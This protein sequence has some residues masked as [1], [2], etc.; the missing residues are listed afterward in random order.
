MN[1]LAAE[2]NK[3]LEGTVAYRLLSD[4]GRRI[5]FPKGIIAQSSEA[6]EK[7]FF[8]NATIG[9]ACKDGVPLRLSEVGRNFPL[10][11][12]AESVGYAPT[13]GVEEL[14]LLWKEQIIKKNPQIKGASISMPVIAPGITAGISYTAD[15]FM[16]AGAQVMAGHPWWDNYSL[17]FEER[18]GAVLKKLSF[19]NSSSSSLDLK[20]IEKELRKEAQNGFLRVILNFPNN[21]SGYS[22][23]VSEAARLVEIIGSI[24]EAGTDVLVLCDDAYFGLFYEEETSKESIFGSLCA[25]NERVLAV[26]IDGPTKEDYVW[27]LRLAAVT[28]GCKG[29]KEDAYEALIKKMMGA[30]RSSVSC[31]SSAS[32]FAYLKACKNGSKEEK[33]RY[34]KMLKERYLAV[35]EF[36]A[37]RESPGALR[38]MPFNSGYFMSFQTIGVCAEELRKALLKKHGIGT[39]AINGDC[40]RVAFASLNKEQIYD[41]YSALYDTAREFTKNPF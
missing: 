24:A 3:T 18:R 10:L 35:K 14:R 16:D 17:I 29:M 38:A 21:P 25:L 39:I 30:V 12:E 7:A 11:N 2:L 13:A 23:T 40:L 37:G 6:K 9:M 20:T 26:K 33:T 5:Y 22:P 36:I 31:A 1:P 8:A 34:F 28:F 4:F 32:Q 27:G 15:V 19:F 41:V